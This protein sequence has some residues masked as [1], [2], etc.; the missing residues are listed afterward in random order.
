M[1]EVKRTT[2][3][4]QEEIER[5]RESLQRHVSA[6]ELTFREK[7][8]WRRPIRERPVVYVGAALGVGLVLGLLV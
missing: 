6:L 2:T 1:G 7:L 4:I 3:E 5:I 8:D